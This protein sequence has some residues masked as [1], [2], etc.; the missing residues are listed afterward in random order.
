MGV[1]ELE[2]RKGRALDGNKTGGSL[3]LRKNSLKFKDVLL[4]NKSVL[5]ASLCPLPP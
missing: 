3:K 4:M 1:T 5:N 2:Y